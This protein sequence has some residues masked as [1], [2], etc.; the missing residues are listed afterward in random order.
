LSEIGKIGL[1]LINFISYLDILNK[2]LQK[3]T[4]IP[5]E[6]LLLLFVAMPIFYDD[7]EY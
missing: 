5:M 7:A 3:N 1:S 2:T 4:G 6:V